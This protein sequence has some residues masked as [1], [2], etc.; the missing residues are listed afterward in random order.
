VVSSMFF[1]AFSPFSTLRQPMI[2]FDA[3]SLT[4]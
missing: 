2:T 1:L 4:K 3:L